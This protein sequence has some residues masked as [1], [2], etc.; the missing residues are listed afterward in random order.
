MPA[1]KYAIARRQLERAGE[2]VVRRDVVG[3]VDERR[4]GQIPS[5]DA[6][7]RAGVVIARAEVGQQR[8][9]WPRHATSSIEAR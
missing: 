7:H 5:D 1:G 6:L 8:D 2:H 4:V 9:D 3:D